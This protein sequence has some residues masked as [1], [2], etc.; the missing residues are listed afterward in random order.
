MK[1]TLE[2]CLRPLKK[3]SQQ[4]QEGAHPG[5]INKGSGF[6]GAQQRE[7]QNKTRM[8]GKVGDGIAETI[9]KIYEEKCPD[10]IRDTQGSRDIPGAEQQRIWKMCLLACPSQNDCKPPPWG[11]FLLPRFLA[12]NFSSIFRSSPLFFLP[13]V[14]FL[15]EHILSHQPAFLSRALVQNSHPVLEEES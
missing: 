13:P 7:R 2:C 8:K 9:S 15:V 1:T 11:F 3:H 10:I 14:C 5:S 6:S 12:N 4:S